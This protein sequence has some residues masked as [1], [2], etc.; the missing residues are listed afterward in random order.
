MGKSTETALSNWKKRF[1]TIW[2]GQAVSQ[3]GSRLVGFAFVWHLTQSTGSATVLAL[4]SLMSLLP[5]VI[6]I[7]FAGVLVDRMNRKAVLIFSD[8]LTALVTLVLAV[9]FTL[10]NVQLW[11]IYAVMFLRSAF[12]TFQYTAM[13]TSTSL[14]VPKSQLSR[15]SG[16][17][18]TLGGALGILA[19]ALGAFLL[20]ILAIES[21][22]FVDVFTALLALIPLLFFQIPKNSHSDHI[23]VQS[24]VKVNIWKDLAEGLKFVNALPGLLW[25]IL[26]AMLINLILTPAFSLLPL[27]VTEYYQKGVLDL[28]LAESVFSVGFIVGGL[29]LSLWGG[30]KNR[31]AT[32]MFFLIVMGVSIVALGAISKTAFFWFIAMLSL[33]G[34]SN[35]LVNGPLMAALQV[36]VPIEKQGRVFSLVSAGASLVSPLGLAVAGPLSDAIGVQLWFIIGGIVC[37][38]LAIISFMNKNVMELGKDAQ[39]SIPLSDPEVL[40]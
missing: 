38:A 9:L 20:G 27:L 18:Q 19:P 39:T 10:S 31:L 16:M 17:N 22:L 3:L 25:I 35:P 21:I 11:Q 28:G 29:I 4:A 40:L 24:K 12:G 34:T 37:I 6:I 14:M 36:K 33:A 26:T 8:I 7:P 32:T 23:D 30:F 5:D 1:F 13:M 15:I 2:A